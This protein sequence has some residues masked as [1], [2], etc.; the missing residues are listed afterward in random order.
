MLSTRSLRPLAPLL[1]LLLLGACV[2]GL[3]SGP[4][5]AASPELGRSLDAIF[6]DTAQAHAHWG[7][8]VRDLGSGATVYERNAEKTFVPASTMKLVTGAAALHALGRGYRYET[9]V[10]AT[11]PVQGGV[12]RGDLVVWGSGD[13]TLSERFTED[14]R[15]TFRAW[16]D[17]LRLRGVQR[18]AG[19]IVGVD[20]VF[21][22]QGPGRGW[23]WDDLAFDYAAEV[24][25]LTLNEGAI[26]VRLFPAARV[27]EPALLDLTPATG[28]LRVENRARTVAA[29]EQTRVTVE[30]AADGLALVV[31]G[32]VPLDATSVE[33]RRSVPDPTGYFVTVLRETLRE[34]GIQVEGAAVDADDREEPVRSAAALPLLFTHRS[35]PLAE[36]LPAML[37]PSQNQIAEALLKTLGAELRGAGTSRAGA[38]AADSLLRSWGIDTRLAVMADGSGMSRYGLATPELF[39][40]LLAHMQRS[41][42]AELWLASLPVGGTDGTLA[43]R[44]RDTPAAGRV[45]AK[46]GT[47]T[48]VAGLAGYVT[49]LDGRRLAFAML[50]NNHVRTAAEARA[51]MDAAVVRIVAGADAARS[52]DR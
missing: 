13:P 48:A 46:T 5:P 44:F 28:Y 49:T 19:G 33:R 52:R 34:A 40:D 30:R 37:K 2:P 7:V 36:I 27:G 39:V 10:L 41:P 4:R 50:G 16:A 12:L 15:A 11:G 24:S 1:S 23:M 32:E 3:A 31:E 45:H 29:G 35:P 21:D 42:H 38:E 26:R 25:G 43:S 17:S 51:A 6:A 20:D 22:D 47:M 18:I 14:A 9:Q 8:L